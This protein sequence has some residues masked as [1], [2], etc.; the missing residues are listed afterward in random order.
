MLKRADED[1][2]SCCKVLA[3]KCEGVFVI[4]AY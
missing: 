2:S 1:L 4:T 3:E